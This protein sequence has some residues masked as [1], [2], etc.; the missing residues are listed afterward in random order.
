MY[1]VVEDVGLK[2]LKRDHTGAEEQTFTRLISL[3]RGVRLEVV[4]VDGWVKGIGK[5][6]CGLTLMRSGVECIWPQIATPDGWEVHGYALVEIEEGNGQCI[7]RTR[8]HFRVA[9]RMD[10]TEH[11]MHARVSTDS[12]TAPPFCPEGGELEWR[13]ASDHLRLDD[14]EYEG[15][16]YAFAYRCPGRAIYQIEDKA[17]WELKGNAAGNTFIMRGGFTHPITRLAEGAY[18]SGWTLP[19]IANPYVFQ[20]LPLYAQLQ[21]FIEGEEAP[22]PP[23]APAAAT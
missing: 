13:I 4:V 6:W 1:E 17:T 21:G 16:S 2:R 22:A 10:W 3:E 12:W 5:V 19:G 14:V 8:P 23:P 11:A 20:H 7:I 15:F 9:Y 18:D